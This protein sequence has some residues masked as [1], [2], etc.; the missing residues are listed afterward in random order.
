MRSARVGVGVWV[1]NAGGVRVMIGVGFVAVAVDAGEVGSGNTTA[2]DT[3]GRGSGKDRIY[4][5]AR[6]PTAAA[7][8]VR[9]PNPVHLMYRTISIL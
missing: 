2:P 6:M 9:H 1:Y 5:A 3:W 7:S 8:N 4:C